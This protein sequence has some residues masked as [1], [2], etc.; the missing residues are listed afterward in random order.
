MDTIREHEV[1]II[2][3]QVEGRSLS[4]G[5]VRV[6]PRAIGQGFGLGL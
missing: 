1:T 3:L 4:L 5:W 6:G 2:S